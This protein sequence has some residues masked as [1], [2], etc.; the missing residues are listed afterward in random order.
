[1]SR[2]FGLLSF[3]DEAEE[4]EEELESVSKTLKS[5]PKSA[6]DIGDPSLLSKKVVE[7]DKSG[8]RSDSSDESGSESEE[9]RG[10]VEKKPEAVKIDEIKSKLERKAAEMASKS[11]SSQK[12]DKKPISE[13][14]QKRK[15]TQ[16]EIR[17]IQRELAD[18]RKQ[19]RDE[20]DKIEEKKIQYNL[21]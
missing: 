15:D 7:E 10:A 6:H 4:E 17:R 19:K 20:D 5:K 16:E 12:A 21:R 11:S 1:M 2:N 3:G 9:K 14:D 18:G 8:R 13:E